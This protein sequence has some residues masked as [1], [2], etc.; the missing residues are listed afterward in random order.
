M[1]CEP[2]LNSWFILISLEVKIEMIWRKR[3]GE[4]KI[5]WE[6]IAK[7]LRADLPFKQ[8]RHVRLCFK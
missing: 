8:Y 3:N 1:K 2:V 5:D 4:K 6:E 7:D